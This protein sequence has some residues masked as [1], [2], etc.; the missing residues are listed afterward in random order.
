MPVAPAVLVRPPLP[1]EPGWLDE[2]HAAANVNTN[3]HV[4][5][6]FI[7]FSKHSARK[8]VTAANRCSTQ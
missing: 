5:V 4:K 1:A 7:E 6:F 8:C 3:K 2:L